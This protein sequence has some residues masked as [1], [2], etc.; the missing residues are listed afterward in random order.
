MRGRGA[1]RRGRARGIGLPPCPPAGRR[2]QGVAE[3]WGTRVRSL[4]AC[5]WVRTLGIGAAVCPRRCDLGEGVCGSRRSR[6]RSVTEATALRLNS[7]IPPTGVGVFPHP[8]AYANVYLSVVSSSGT[9][10]Y[11]TVAKISTC[12]ITLYYSHYRKL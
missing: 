5:W 6:L 12:I 7:G 4:R 3:E 9:T 2:Q 11:P 8:L 10:L 1:A